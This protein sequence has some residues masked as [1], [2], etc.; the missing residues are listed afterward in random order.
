MKAFIMAAGKGTRLAPLTNRKPKALVEVNGK[1]MLKLLIEYLKKQGFDQFLINI[2]H[3]GSL[4]ID[5]LK[6]NNNFDVSIEISD[7]RNQLLDTGGAIVKAARFF[8]GEEPVLVHNVDI[9]SN[10]DFVTLIEQHKNTKA[11]VT[12]LTRNRNSSR[13]LLFNKHMHLTGWV[14]LNTGE[15]KWVNNPTNQ[16]IA[17]AYSGIYV[18]SADYPDK[19]KA[20]GSFSIVPRW[21]QMARTEIII[22]TE[23]NN[24]YWFDLGSIKKIKE[25]EEIL[26]ANGE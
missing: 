22:G 13:K 2:H 4:I 17:R 6:Q 3:H 18:A 15:Y 23:D 12:L 1:P 8:K 20:R 21:L 16:Y 14:N 11:L 19:I 10:T 24:G 5:F 26:N 7:E 9:I 25:A